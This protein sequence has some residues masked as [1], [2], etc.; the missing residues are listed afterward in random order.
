MENPMIVNTE[1]RKSQEEERINLRCSQETFTN[2]ITAGSNCSEFEAKQIT[3]KAIEVFDL[4]EHSDSQRMFPGQML[5]N[6]IDATEPPGKPL[7]KCIFKRIVLTLHEIAEDT[8]IKHRDGSRAKRI[9]QILRISNEAYDQGTCLTIEDL[10][11]I[12]GS[13]EKTIRTDIKRYRSE[14]PDVV[15]P[16]RGNK[17]DIGPGVTHREQTLRLFLTGKDPEAISMHLNHSL[18][19]VERYI[20]SFSRVVFCQSKVHNSL[21][22]ALITGYSIALVNLCLSLKNEFMKTVH[23]KDRLEII[24]RIGTQYWEVQDAKKKNGQEIGRGK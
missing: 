6:A 2:I 23:Y 12:L 3:K 22:T 8:I 14:H 5:W 19:A 17:C 9:R 4:G 10:S 15:V 1:M 24:E 16:T 7:S 13:D 18:K 11:I 20:T 21:Q